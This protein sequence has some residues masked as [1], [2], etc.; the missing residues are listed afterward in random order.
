MKTNWNSE[1]FW[2]P[3]Y[4]WDCFL[5]FPPFLRWWQCKM[6]NI[7]CPLKLASWG[8]AL[9][10]ALGDRN[11]II[12]SWNSLEGRELSVFYSLSRCHRWPPL[13]KHPDTS[14]MAVVEWP[15]GNKISSALLSWPLWHDFL[16]LW[17]GCQPAS[18]SLCHPPVDLEG[19]FLDLNEGSI[20]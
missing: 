11:E 1:I 4:I 13:R 17:E 7:F 5:S 9:G 10:T 3:Q 8:S 12:F 14:T 15:E 20:Y 16:V 2:W 6:R 18:C 19:T